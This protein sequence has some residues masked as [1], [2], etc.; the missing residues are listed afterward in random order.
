MGSATNYYS[1]ESGSLLDYFWLSSGSGEHA[2]G[3]TGGGCSHVI[4][5]DNIFRELNKAGMSRKLY[6]ES[7]P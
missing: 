6:A 1:D 7:F 3:C 2:Y 5:S 4:P